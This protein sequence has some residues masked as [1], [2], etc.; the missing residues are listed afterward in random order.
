V[1]PDVLSFLVLKLFFTGEMLL[2]RVQT[3][4]LALFSFLAFNLLFSVPNWGGK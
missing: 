1:E 2:A 4:K 3:L